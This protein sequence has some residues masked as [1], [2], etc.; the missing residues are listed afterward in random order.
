MKRQ[1]RKRHLLIILILVLLAL[2]S[3]TAR[4][5]ADGVPVLL[6]HQIVPDREYEKMEKNDSVMPV[7]EFKKQMQMIAD[8]G[9]QTISL[10]ELQLHITGDQPAPDRSIVIT[11]DDGYRSDLTLAYPILKSHGFQAET[12]IVTSFLNE[13]SGDPERLSSREIL[14]LK[15][16]FG[17][18]SHSHDLHTYE[19]ENNPLSDLL[20]ENLTW[21]TDLSLQ[22]LE[23]KGLKDKTDLDAYAYPYGKYDERFMEILSFLKVDLA[24]TTEKGYVRPGCNP[25]SLPRFG[26]Y[27]GRFGQLYR[28]LN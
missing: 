9:Y 7:K 18:H 4:K 15:D 23:H 24:F 19:Y 16:V 27:P 11:F 3:L 13:E 1:I 12:F 26:M 25:L 20:T 6:Y 22:T 17:I 21:D 10:E 28:V 8:A 5:P 2:F 14:Q